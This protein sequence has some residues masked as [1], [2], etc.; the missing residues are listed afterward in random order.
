MFQDEDLEK[1]TKDELQELAVL[2][3]IR[4]IV[5]HLNWRALNSTSIYNKKEI[6]ENKKYESTKEAYAE[7]VDA[8]CAKYR[9]IGPGS[10]FY[11]YMTEEL[12]QEYV[13]SLPETEEYH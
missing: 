7:L 9:A 2:F 11:D 12:W 5:Q 3:P 8:Y 1:L 13:N 10:W 4:Q 6:I